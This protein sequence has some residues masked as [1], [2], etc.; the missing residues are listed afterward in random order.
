MFSNFRFGSSTV[1]C[2]FPFLGYVVW[3]GTTAGVG[4]LVEIREEKIDV[5]SI[6][7]ITKKVIDIIDSI[8][9]K[10]NVFVNITA[11]RKPQSLGVVFAAYQRANRIN[12]I[13][14][15]TEEKK[16]IVMLPKLS[17][18]LTT[19]QLEILRNIDKS[20][21]ITKLEKIL[22]IGRAM[23]YRNVKGLQNKGFIEK[24]EN[25]LRLTD[26]GKIAI[27]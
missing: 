19:S 15:I 22:E 11:G 25:G 13:V 21:S 1:Q 24:S 6:V 10:D 7:D 20:D 14:Y 5:Y 16:D 3:V 18:Y 27:L 8:S 4:N 26:S 12:K 2:I 23:I 17:F 9:E